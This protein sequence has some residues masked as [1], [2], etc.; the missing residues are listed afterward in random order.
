MRRSPGGSIWSRAAGGRRRAKLCL[1]NTDVNDFGKPP[2]ETLTPSGLSDSS[3]LG[4]R[5]IEAHPRQA[6][7]TRAG[8][9]LHLHVGLRADEFTELC[10][11]V[12]PRVEGRVALDQVGPDLAEVGPAVVLGGAADRHREQALEVGE[13]GPRRLVT[14]GL[15]RGVFRLFAQEVEVDEAV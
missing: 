6:Q 4:N 12:V 9:V 2:R 1:W 3:A 13:P 15:R 7:T 14:V 11:A 5:W 10:V 8:N